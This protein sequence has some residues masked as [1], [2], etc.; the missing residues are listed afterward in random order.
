VSPAQRLDLSLGQELALLP[1]MLQSIEL[2]QLPCAELETWLVR[3]AQENEALEV[4]IARAR[5][6]REGGRRRSRADGGGHSAWLEAQPERPRGLVDRIEAEL[7]LCEIDAAT[8]AWVDLLVERLD[9]HGFLACERAALL[10]AA[11]ERGLAGGETEL[12]RALGVLHSLEPRGI[13][14]RD[15]IE[16]LLLQLDPSD[17]DYGELRRLLADFL[18]ELAANKLPAVARA[19]GVE[20]GELRRLLARLRE[21]D[22]RPAA[23]LA[24]ESAAPIVPDVVVERDG[25]GFEVEV[26]GAALPA[27]RVDPQLERLARDGAQPREVR[28]YLRDKVARARWIVGALEQRRR[29]LARIARAAFARQ[30]AFLEHG[31]GHLVPLRMR[32]LARELGLHVSTV[33][34]AVAGK[35][36]QTPWGVVA[37]RSLFQAP[38]P[39]SETA[40]RDDVR[41]LVRETIEAED[42]ARPWSDDDVAARL[43]ERGVHVARRTV[44]KYRRELGIASSYRRRRY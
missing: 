12:D 15:A 4:E 11:R 26:A 13:G 3:E 25:D 16:A 42:P 20:I 37:L 35:H 18:R 14:A 21:L 6:P 10:S 39:R 28:R 27:A 34:R 29:T 44:A 30:I 24:D 2:L 8:R 31:P 1:R 22:P 41:E 38:A 9:A 43:A 40:A 17:P 19:M 33:S 5:P 7:A 36:A 32:D 23:A